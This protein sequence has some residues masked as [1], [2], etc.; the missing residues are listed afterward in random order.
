[1]Q[2]PVADGQFTGVSPPVRRTVLRV[3]VKRGASVSWIVWDWLCVCES[4]EVSP[5]SAI[6]RLKCLPGL[7]DRVWDVQWSGGSGSVL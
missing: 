6:R 2:N 3:L 7:F 4:W 5:G 1:M